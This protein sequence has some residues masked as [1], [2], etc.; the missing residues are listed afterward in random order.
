[1]KKCFSRARASAHVIPVFKSLDPGCLTVNH[2]F[3]RGSASF[4]MKRSQ[5]SSSPGGILSG[6][7]R[8]P[9]Y[10]KSVGILKR[11]VSKHTD[12]ALTLR[13]V[14]FRDVMGSLV[15]KIGC[16]NVSMGTRKML[17]KAY[18]RM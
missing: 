7:V 11:S 15:L 17:H 1:M 2:P 4:R 13:V 9:V 16:R 3:T 5:F 8:T 6:F 12:S 14:L 18:F 10:N